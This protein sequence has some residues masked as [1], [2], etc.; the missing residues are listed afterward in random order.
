[1]WQLLEVFFTSRYRIWRLFSL[2]R[3]FA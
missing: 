3:Y 1:M 2:L